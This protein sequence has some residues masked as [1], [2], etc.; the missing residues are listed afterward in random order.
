[1]A[2][3]T[4]KRSRNIAA[5]HAA[6]RYVRSKMDIG[7][8]NRIGP[9]MIARLLCAGGTFTKGEMRTRIDQELAGMQRPTTR[10]ELNVT[11][12]SSK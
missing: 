6:V 4:A 2:T 8:S 7:A 9:G 11:A 12:D 5:T 1:M 3:P 10:D